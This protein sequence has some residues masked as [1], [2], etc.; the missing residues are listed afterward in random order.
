MLVA[1]N[2]NGVKKENPKFLVSGHSILIP[3]LVYQS[4]FY[5]KEI[6]FPLCVEKVSLVHP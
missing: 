4:M 1:K 6:Y 5:K 3:Y 2:R